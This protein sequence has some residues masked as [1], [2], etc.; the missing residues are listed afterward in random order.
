[1]PKR[2]LLGVGTAYHWQ[3]NTPRGCFWP[4]CD[5]VGMAIP[6]FPMGGSQPKA[7]L[8]ISYYDGK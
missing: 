3:L 6:V 4:L 8:E 2:Q 7:A 5:L 1:M